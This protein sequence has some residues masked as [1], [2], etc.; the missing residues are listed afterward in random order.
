MG[1]VTV[2]DRVAGGDSSW[3]ERLDASERLQQQ[4]YDDIN[5]VYEKHYG[6]EWSRQYRHRFI[7]ETM[8]A[9]V[10]LSGK[11]VLDALCGSGQTTEYLL[12]RGAQ[13]TGLD[14]SEEA[15]DSFRNRFPDAKAVNRSLLESGF[16]DN[17]F[18]YVVIV[19][20]LHHLHP[21]LRSAV[22]E[23]C[24]VLKPGGLFCFMEPHT[25][26]LPDLVRQ[27]WYKHDRY[28]S[29]NEAAIDLDRFQ[30][31]FGKWF[32]PKKL[33]YLGNVAFLLV[34]NSL[35]FRVPLSLKRFYSPALLAIEGWLNRLQGKRTSCFVTAQWQKL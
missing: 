5:A 10:D 15:I 21:N 25:G 12:E 34:L 9:G 19:G 35:I 18:D 31:D 26:S 20:G 30:R 2:V 23:I 3:C 6:D 1:S 29:D 7:H 4:H 32:A 14:I 28:F 27:V 11:K 33:C 16:A 17:T 22:S 13:V 24:R 8:F